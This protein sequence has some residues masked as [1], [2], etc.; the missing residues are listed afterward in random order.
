M[1]RLLL[2]QGVPRSCATLLRDKGWDVVHV[3]EL[4][5]CRAADLEILRYARED[6]RHIVT[7]DADFHHYLVLSGEIRPSVIRIR[8]EGLKGMDVAERLERSWAAMEEALADG[9]MVSITA[10]AVRIRRLPVSSS[11]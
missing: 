10:Q 3:G 9:A 6:A 1:T 5:M 4:G 11:S 7:L 2:D 8:I